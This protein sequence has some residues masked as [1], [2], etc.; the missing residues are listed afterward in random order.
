MTKLATKYAVVKIG[1]KEYVLPLDKAMQF[2]EL[3]EEA[4]RYEYKY[5]K[6]GS[7]YHIWAEDPD[8]GKQSLTILSHSLYNLAKMAGQP[9]ND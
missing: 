9:S 5:N 3:M 1:W 8:E 4:E 6:D 7:T 2:L